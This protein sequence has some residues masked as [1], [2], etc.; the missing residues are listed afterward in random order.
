M[1]K[2]LKSNRG[3]AAVEFALVALPV[4]WMILGIMQFGYV[5][6]TDNLLHFSVN[7][8]A[9]CGAVQSTTVPCVGPW[10]ASDGGLANMTQTANAVFR[11][12][13]A[14]YALNSSNCSGDAGYGLVGTYQVKFVFAVTLTMTAESCYPKVS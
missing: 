8:A 13:G 1:K 4:F 2:V 6:W 9:R 5:L 11:L 12:S 10:P 14:T 7:T 3:A